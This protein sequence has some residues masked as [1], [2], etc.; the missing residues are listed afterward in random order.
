MVCCHVQ[1]K[2]KRSSDFNRRSKTLVGTVRA[3]VTVAHNYS[4]QSLNSTELGKEKLRQQLAE[5]LC[6]MDHDA[7]MN[8]HN[9]F[10]NINEKRLHLCAV[11]AYKSFTV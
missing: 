7:L 4:I 9:T 1:E 11:F 10:L 6:Y 8:K 2:I 3:D 5:V